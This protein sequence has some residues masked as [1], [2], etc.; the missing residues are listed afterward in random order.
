MCLCVNLFL[1]VQNVCG[2][3]HLCSNCDKQYEFLRY[4]IYDEP[5]RY[6]I[7]DELLRYGI[8][9]Y[10]V[11]YLNLFSVGDHILRFF[12]RYCSL[13][14]DHYNVTLNAASQID[15]QM[16]RPNIVLLITS[17]SFT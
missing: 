3:C 12:S 10:D 11:L 5:L 14:C 8:Y 6:G 1:S 13:L 7:Y 15:L 4:G 16:Y 17:K 2:I 9:D